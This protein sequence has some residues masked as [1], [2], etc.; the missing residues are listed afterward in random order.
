MGYVKPDLRLMD[1]G[2]ID[3]LSDAD[4]FVSTLVP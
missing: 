3:T 4:D 1:V 2:K